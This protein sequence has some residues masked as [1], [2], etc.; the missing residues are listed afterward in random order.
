MGIS[1][2]NRSGH[3]DRQLDSKGRF[4]L[5]VDWRPPSGESIYFVKVK[6]E[7]IPALRVF[8]QRAF[9]RK[10]ADIDSADEATPAQRDRARGILFGASLESKVNDQGK[11][12]I[13][14]ALAESHGLTLPGAL[15]LV[16]RGELFEIFTPENGDA[17]LALEEE[18]RQ[19]D[20]AIAAMLGF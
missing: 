17:I 13:P 2:H 15:R 16:G 18:T 12:T 5:L 19:S 1:S 20:P 14:K 6:V 7:G 4:S 11:L 9:D 10:L 8:T 3:H